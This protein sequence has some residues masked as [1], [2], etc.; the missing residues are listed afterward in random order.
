MI[1]ADKI[2]NL[3][4][5][6]GWSQEELAYQVGVSR[7]AV[8]KWESAQSI[9]EI[10]KI[11]LMSQIFEV[12]TDFLIKEEYEV[13]DRF[14]RE[15]TLEHSYED[16]PINPLRK[17]T[18]EE[19]NEYLNLKESSI[20]K[21]A[22]GVFLTVLSP[23]FLIVLLALAESPYTVISQNMATGLG[24]ITLLL[25]VASGVMLF[26][27]SSL[28]A[29]KYD[30]LDR[31]PIDT[32]YGVKGMVKELKDN[33]HSRYVSSIMTGVLLSILSIVPLFIGIAMN[34]TG[35]IILILVSLIFVIIGIATTLF[36]SA[37]IR[38]SSYEK[39]LQEGEYT[40]QNKHQSKKTDSIFGI[41][42]MIVLAIF[43]AYS[44]LTNDWG[45]SWIIWPV[46]SVLFGAFV[47]IVRTIVDKDR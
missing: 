8:S 9:P 19:A 33:F 7:Q 35:W 20:K 39:L 30:F 38:Q 46:S 34:V 18:L 23:A 26:I 22:L 31:E 2:S 6:K 14:D 45:R 28:N 15:D 17:V 41:Y 32:A 27:A 4:K 37:G 29:K 13:E 36:V 47:L 10:E 24:L 3:R 40:P 44:F 42:W 25:L 12:T 5:Q 11:L 16:N 21:V 43:L 1:L